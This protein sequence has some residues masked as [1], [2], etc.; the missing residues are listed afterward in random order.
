VTV[1]LRAQQIIAYESG[2]ANTVDPLAGSFFVEKLTDE[3]EA[4]A[5]ALIKQIDDRGGVVAAIE[6]GFIQKQIEQSAYRFG[7]SIDNG[8]RV[9]VGVNKF[10]SG[11]DPDVDLFEVPESTTKR[12]IDKLKSVRQKRDAKKVEA[13]L[14]AVAKSAASDEN[15]MPPIIEAV[16]EYATVGEICRAL[17][18]VFGEYAES[19]S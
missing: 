8:Q 15:L 6:Q 4:E 18:G 1:A 11:G 19:H 14:A 17:A 10:T 2:V 12:Q 5:E 13:A 16:R 7:Q 3:L 9:I